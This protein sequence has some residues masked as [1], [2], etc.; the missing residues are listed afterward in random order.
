MTKTAK[1]HIANWLLAIALLN[2]PFYENMGQYNTLQWLEMLYNFGAIIVLYYL[3]H[4]L[5]SRYYNRLSKYK[6]H[7]LTGIQKNMYNLKNKYVM[8]VIASLVMYIAVSIFMDNYCFERPAPWRMIAL[9]MAA[10]INNAR[11]Q[12]QAQKMQVVVNTVK[13]Q[14][15][16]L[17]NKLS[18]VKEL[19]TRLKD[20][21]TG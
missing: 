9:F 18:K 10:A 2:L 14:N 17:R 1:Q 4:H 8:M 15:D 11:Q 16:D 3:A 13:L 19:Y 6:Y 12:C 21:L 20:G 5:M 7:S